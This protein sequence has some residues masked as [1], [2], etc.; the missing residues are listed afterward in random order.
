MHQVLYFVYSQFVKDRSGEYEEGYKRKSL[1]FMHSILQQPSY[2]YASCVII[3]SVYQEEC[4]LNTTGIKE[5][6][7]QLLETLQ[8]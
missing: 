1:V 5:Y 3:I 6:F 8:N 7:T 2:C 4:K